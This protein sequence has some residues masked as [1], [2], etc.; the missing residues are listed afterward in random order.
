MNLPKHQL[1]NTSCADFLLDLVAHRLT[2]LTL[3]QLMEIAT[4]AGFNDGK[5][6]TQIR[7][8]WTMGLLYRGIRN[9]VPTPNATCWY[10][11]R[12]PTQVD[13]VI[14]KF[15][16]DEVVRRQLPTEVTELIG[17]GPLAAGLL[18]ITRPIEPNHQQ[19]AAQQRLALAYKMHFANGLEPEQWQQLQSHQFLARLAAVAQMTSPCGN[20][21]RLIVAPYATS[22]LRIERLIKRINELQVPY[23]LW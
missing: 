7:R 18:G 16:A 6:R 1:A 11:S 14:Q 2:W 3:P 20:S 22:R 13:A 8:C 9:A 23:E 17:I 19:L 21:H 15:V 4:Q 10:D 5:V 12:R